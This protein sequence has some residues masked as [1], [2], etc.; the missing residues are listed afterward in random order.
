MAASVHIHLCYTH[1]E[2]AGLWLM[3]MLT[4]ANY[5]QSACCSTLHCFTVS[6]Y[7]CPSK[8]ALLSTPLPSPPL[9]S[10]PLSSPPPAPPPASSPEM[11]MQTGAKWVI[12]GHSERRDIFGETDEVRVHISGAGVCAL[13]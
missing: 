3:G 13:L 5:S 1:I 8:P 2:I 9:P 12:L 6:I 10:A 4:R 11:V 7:S